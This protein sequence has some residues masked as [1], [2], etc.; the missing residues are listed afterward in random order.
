M[1]AKKSPAVARTK[2][3]ASGATERASAELAPV[4]SRTPSAAET[5]PSTSATRPKRRRPAPRKRLAA[6][7]LEEPARLSS[8]LQ[9]RA[10][11]QSDKRLPNRGEAGPAPQRKQPARSSTSP[12]APSREMRR[13]SARRRRRLLRRASGV[14]DR[15]PLRGR[16]GHVAE[17]LQARHLRGCEGRVQR[18][19][20]SVPAGLPLRG[21]GR[22]RTGLHPS[23]GRRGGVPR[24]LVLRQGSVL[25]PAVGEVHQPREGRRR[26]RRVDPVR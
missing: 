15:H 21:G 22:S 11:K 24:R 19:R 2:K 3:R 20:H 13:G 18:L 25:Q 5:G 8:K 17:D 23:A 1:P 12:R 4:R 14:R 6:S 16:A 7:R 26:L 9:G 10:A